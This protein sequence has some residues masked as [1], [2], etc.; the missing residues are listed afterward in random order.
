MFDKIVIIPTFNEKENIEKIIRA[1]F[2]LEGE[3]HILVVDDNSPDG[4]GKIVKELKKEF[5]QR[6]HL[7]HRE[8]KSGLGSAYIAGFQWAME[9][10]YNFIFEMDADFSHNPSDLPRLYNCCKE[11]ADLAIGSRYSKGISVVNW[12]IG[13]VVISYFASTYV[14]WVLKMKIFDATAG[15]KCYRNEVL[16]SIDLD[17]IKMRG[18]GFQIEMKYNAYKLGFKIKEV[19]IIFVDRTEGSSKMNSSI[20]GEAFWGVIAMRFRKIKGKRR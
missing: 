2:A 8:T 13:R 16:E 5:L 12:P 15:F 14:R 9:K 6:L 17:S 20:F 3:Y 10:N 11:G 4:T 18:Y 7:L 19:P 1:I